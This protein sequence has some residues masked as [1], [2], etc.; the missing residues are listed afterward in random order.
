M[1][2][3]AAAYPID[4]H[5]SWADYAAKITRWVTEA[6]N[7]GA[8]LLVFPEY[9]AMELAALDGPDDAGDVKLCQ[10]SVSSRMDDLASLLHDLAVKHN[11]HILG[12]SGP[13]FEGDYTVNRAFFCTPYGIT[14]Q[15]K[16]IMTRF[17][18]DEMDIRTGGPLRV[19]DTDLGRIGITICYDSEFPLLARKLMEEGVEILLVPSATE[20]MAGYSRVRIGAMA[21]ALEGQCVAIHSPTVGSA[22]WNPVVDE[23][24][25]AAGIYG[26]PDMGFPDTG[27]IAQGEMN[28]PGWVYAD[29]DLDAIRHVRADGHVLNKLHWDEQTTRV[30]SVTQVDLR[31]D[32]A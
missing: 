3:A 32:S 10:Y 2:V 9:G 20:G 13:M 6:A 28:Q 15:D 17:E 24:T 1:K 22:P 12:P 16:Q 8:Q 25:G 23:N 4:W 27:V 29:I 18:R 26:P 19:I 11:L 21:R 30:Q 14:H 31:R 5:D 7:Q